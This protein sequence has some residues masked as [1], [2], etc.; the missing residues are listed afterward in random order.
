MNKI[1]R[2]VLHNTV[3]QRLV[4][5]LLVLVAGCG[6]PATQ[7]GPDRGGDQPSGTPR[8]TVATPVRK[9]LVRKIV[10]PGEIRA[11][12][13]T[14][15]FAG[16]SGFVGQ[17]HKDISDPVSPGEILA[18]LSVPERDEELNQKKAKVSQARA[19]VEQAKKLLVAAE[20]DVKGATARVREFEAGRLR[21]S[22]TLRRA[23][24]QYERLKKSTAV[25]AQEVIDETR[26]GF[27]AAQAAVAEVEAKVTSADADRLSQEAKRDKA[28]ADIGVAAARLRVAEA[29]ERYMTELLRYAKLRAPFA[30]VITRRNIDPGHF[31][32]ANAGKS[33]G[34]P[35]FV[36]ARVDK[37]RVFVEVQENDAVL[38]TNGTRAVVTVQGL[39][40]EE[41]PGEVTRSAVA[42]DPKAG[43][44]L[45][46]EIDL[47]NPGGRLRPGMY[48][49]ATLTAKRQDVLT[50]PA[51]AVVVQGEQA[52][53]FLLQ[54]DKVR[55]VAIKVGVRDGQLIEV[56]KKQ[57]A[58]KDGG[59]EDFTGEETIVTSNPAAL[60]DG[61]VV[62]V[63]PRA[64]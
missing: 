13:Q 37:V 59:W 48:A 46:T 36:I 9:T 19:E 28:R 3:G 12:E 40:G 51:A 49:I 15:M 16:I 8:V 18:E 22:A 5:P 35:A 60:T 38:V 41:F 45:R 53:C 54:G 20:A 32:Q 61:Q 6:G 14:P 64:P 62:M 25:L 33:G 58:G 47:K 24:S 44:T 4:L 29:N 43:R 34:E 27:E 23:E 17:V 11:F 31:L 55:R 52:F 7:S 2:P 39:N 42:L 26:L 1:G 30:G 57:S 63:A 21:A 50:V 56:A 10:Q